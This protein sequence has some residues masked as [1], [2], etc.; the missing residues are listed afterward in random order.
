MN[1]FLIVIVIFLSIVLVPSDHAHADGALL[2]VEIYVGKINS[3]REFAASGGI[4]ISYGWEFEGTKYTVFMEVDSKWYNTNRGQPHGE[5]SYDLSLFP[6]M[7]DEGRKALPDLVREFKKVFP[8][9]WSDQKKVNFVLT[10]VQSIRYETD[11]EVHGYDE[12]YKYVTETLVEGVG[13]CEDSSILFASIL[14]GLG[15]ESALIDLPR[16][17]AVGIKGN[18]LGEYMFSLRENEKYFFC[19]TTGIG[20][21]VGQ[22]PPDF[23]YTDAELMP[24]TSEPVEPEKVSPAVNPPMP[25]FPERLSPQQALEEGIKLAKDARYN[26]A[27]NTL[28]SCLRGLKKP[29]QRAEVY[30]YLGRAMW[31]FGEGKDETEGEKIV[32]KQFQEALR[33]NPNILETPWPDHL[34]FEE[35]FQEVREESIGKLTVTASLPKI[36]IWIEE[37]GINR[38]RLDIGTFRLFKGNY[39]VEVIYE[40]GSIKKQVKI[41]PNSN[42]E[43]GP[44][45]LPPIVK[46]EPLSEVSVG[47]LI[48][49]TSD[50]ISHE[51]PERVQVY[52]TTYNK[53][54]REIEQGRK[55]MRLKS[56]SSTWG[57]DVFLPPLKQAGLIQYHIKVEYSDLPVVRHPE[58]QYRYHQISVVDDEPPS[59]NTPPKI[60]LLDRIQKTKVHRSI[61]LK[62][63]VTD[64]NS[65]KLVYLWYGF[66]QFRDQKPSQYEY[67]PMVL[68]KNNSDRYTGY[69]P[70]QSK[71]G[72]IWYY[73]TAE[74]E[75][76]NESRYPQ[77]SR[78]L[79]EIEVGVPREPVAPPVEPHVPDPEPDPG[80]QQVRRDASDSQ[81]R[82]KGFWI[83]GLFDIASTSNLS[84]SD[85]LSVAFLR[86]GK[87]HYTLGAQ[88]DFNYQ[89][90]VDWRFTI[91]GGPALGKSRFALT[92][93]LGGAEYS[94]SDFESRI[95]P[96][97]GVS[98]K[99]YLLN[100]VTIEATGL[101]KPFRSTFD[102]TPI[103]HYDLGVRIYIRRFLNLK[104]GYG[105]WYLGSRDIKRV[106]I[107]LGYIF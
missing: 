83:T 68:S 96:I 39:T 89:E 4:E 107:G 18:F 56:A 86:E 53:N 51:K 88:F 17:I 42:V 50:I 22:I 40:G 97:L 29:E 72:Y 103:Y 77:T 41:K 49:F 69:I 57:Y 10:F 80:E 30:F 59:D 25:K 78:G 62:A 87:T 52:Y 90:P 19:E 9:D 100:N 32:K 45:I 23:K 60:V 84:D 15:F 48:Y 20:W 6:Q 82:Y 94:I 31:G 66:S 1:N 24:I 85:A 63:E 105:G 28:K 8:S 11:R 76:G 95:T 5:R 2:N 67:E 12:L 3:Y 27:I 36:E 55:K 38:K 81:W 47:E 54:K 98:A 21:Q 104:V 34:R 26:E 106:Q 70:S 73:L 44:E 101:L 13:D 64:E 61:V 91:Q 7:V 71:S 14:S 58:N 74:D 43:I 16:H 35:W 37:N 33:Q 79:L 65:V 46:H 99:Y 102:T 75:D 93:H 92:G